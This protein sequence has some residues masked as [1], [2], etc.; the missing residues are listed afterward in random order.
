MYG[1]RI[2]SVPIWGVESVNEFNLG[3]QSLVA[4]KRRRQNTSRISNSTQG[5][6]E[7]RRQPQETIASERAQDK[8]Q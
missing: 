5:N 8:E 7:S 4:T 3:F 2:R 6:R 1:A